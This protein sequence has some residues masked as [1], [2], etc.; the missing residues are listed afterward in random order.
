LTEVE[1]ILK[2]R[3]LKSTEVRKSVLS[4]FLE[5]N[6]ALSHAD[7]EDML[8]D[9][10]K[11]TLYRTLHAFEESGIIHLAQ[12]ETDSKQYAICKDNCSI[13][14]HDHNHIHFFCKKCDKTFCIPQK[15]QIHNSL[16]VG[17]VSDEVVVLIKGFCSSCNH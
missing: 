6:Y 12:S 8:K 11:V 9:V 15:Y 10:D 16:P 1:K 17:Y 7:I 14:K 13:E 5:H 2:K 3:K 4:V